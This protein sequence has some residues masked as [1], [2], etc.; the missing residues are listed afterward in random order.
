MV[1]WNNT[2]FA[3]LKHSLYT[4]DHNANIDFFFKS[5]DQIY[6]PRELEPSRSTK[7]ELAQF[8]GKLQSWYMLLK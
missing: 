4:N 3:T 7:E 5:I 6:T 2:S 8:I 1:T